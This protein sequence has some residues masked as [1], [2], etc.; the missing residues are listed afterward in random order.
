MSLTLGVSLGAAAA[1]VAA[2]YYGKKMATTP[3]KR[4]GLL[5]AMPPEIAKLEEHVENQ[6]KHQRG[7]FE[8]TTGTLDGKDVVFAASNVRS[9]TSATTRTH[10][11]SP[12]FA[13]PIFFRHA[14]GPCGG[15]R[16]V[17]SSRR[18]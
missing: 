3:T 6:V 10:M 14:R 16:L 17:W 9:L 13:Q 15:G 4:I 5:A 7:M 1:A 8:F 2:Y 12:L 18:A 11:L